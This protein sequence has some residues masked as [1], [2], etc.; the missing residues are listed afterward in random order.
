MIVG[1]LFIT[2][3]AVRQFRERIPGMWRL[4][5]EQALGLIL[6]ALRENTA[7]VKPT[8]N[9]CGVSIRV[10]GE[11]NFRAIAARGEGVKP[12]VVTILRSGK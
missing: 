12:A 6:R 8:P 11:L 7:S 5:Y 3:H 2:P 4:K 9:G 1:D 10:R